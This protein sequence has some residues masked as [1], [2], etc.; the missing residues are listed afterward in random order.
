[1]RKFIIWTFLEIISLF[2]GL[3]SFVLI[4]FGFSLSLG[5][6]N[7]YI[8]KFLGN[9]KDIDSILINAGVGLATASMM[10]YVALQVR[11]IRKDRDL[12]LRKEHT[13]EL[14][15]KVVIPWI[16]ELKKISEPKKEY[17]PWP[18]HYLIHSIYMGQSLAIERKEE[19]LF[20]DFLENHASE[21]LII[22]HKKFKE[23]CKIL[24]ELTEE[25]KNKVE[26]FLKENGI[27]LLH[28][29]KINN[30]IKSK[31]IENKHHGVFYKDATL[32]FFLDNLI[33]E[34]N[35]KV[36]FSDGGK[37]GNYQTLGFYCKNSKPGGYIHPN[38]TEETKQ[39]VKTT[40]EN[41]LKEAKEKFKDDIKEIHRLI[42]EINKNKEIMLKELEKFKYKRI[43]DGDCEFIKYP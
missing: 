11:E 14:R 36:E 21:E 15:K 23:S 2:F 20:N 1:M 27:E 28:Y 22:S 18:F 38:I 13:E 25:L 16:E 5:F 17:P 35:G 4:I 26:N 41:L 42:D 34:S 40:I 32:E 8:S 43:Y 3:F 29:R 39:Y 7:E 30:M 19:I 10:V 12:S 37:H 24:Y 6:G 33:R 31:E 9:P